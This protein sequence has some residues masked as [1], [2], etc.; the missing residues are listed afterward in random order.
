MPKD[1]VISLNERR[2]ARGSVFSFPKSANAFPIVTRALVGR[3]TGGQELPVTS[4]KGVFR[5]SGGRAQCVGV[6]GYGYKPMPNAEL[7]AAVEDSF[8]NCMTPA[9]METVICKDRASYAGARTIREYIF[10]AFG[11][12][13]KAD[14]T[15]SEMG[16]RSVVYNSYDGSTPFGITT[17]LIDFY[18]DNGQVLGEY[19]LASRKHTSGA[20]IRA[21]TPIIADSLDR[22]KE[23]IRRLQVWATREIDDSEAETLLRRAFSKRKA[24]GLMARFLTEGEER[25]YTLWAL[26]S[27]LTFYASHNTEA[28][29]IRNPGNMANEA[30]VLLDREREVAKI[31]ASP[32]WEA[33]EAA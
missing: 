28:F 4:H 17:G 32:M 8:R 19:D 21:V 2:D 1:N 14:G 31:V 7:Y 11:G 22:I 6:V 26:H 5:Q 12:T 23:R 15:V 3:G 27:A 25:G 10:P 30:T 29:N 9:E 33:L 20:Q 13:I 24:E 18:C 16:Y